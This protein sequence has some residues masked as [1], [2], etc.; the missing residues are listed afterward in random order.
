MFISKSVFSPDDEMNSQS[1]DSIQY[2]TKHKSKQYSNTSKQ[3]KN[4]TTNK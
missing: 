3:Q 2:F 1:D 4:K